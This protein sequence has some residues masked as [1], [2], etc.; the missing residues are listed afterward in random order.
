MLLYFTVC[1]NDFPKNIC[2]LEYLLVKTFVCK[3]FWLKKVLAI[4]MLVMKK[5]GSQNV[6]HK[7]FCVEMILARKNPILK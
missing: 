2:P 3:K 5:F 1:K 7:F 6:V 4:K